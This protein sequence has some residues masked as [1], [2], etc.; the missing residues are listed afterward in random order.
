LARLKPFSRQR[1]CGENRIEERKQSNSRHC[2]SSDDPSGKWIFSA[3]G[4]CCQR[5]H[6]N[7]TDGSMS[8]KKRAERTPVTNK[9]GM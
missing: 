3:N 5:Q 2:E 4:Y 6:M 7:G 1:H 8:C 9:K